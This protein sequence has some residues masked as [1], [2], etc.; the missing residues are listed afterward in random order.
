MS[1]EYW[2]PLARIH[3]G[4]LSESP[5]NLPN[6]LACMFLKVLPIL[7]GTWRGSIPVDSDG[8]FEVESLQLTV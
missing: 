2:P 4:I 8:T 5:S 6:E 1:L 7:K 3:W